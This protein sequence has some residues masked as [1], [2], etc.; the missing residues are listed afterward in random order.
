MEAV[1]ESL[2]EQLG[3]EPTIS[4][5]AKALDMDVKTFSTRLSEGRE[6]KDRMI[7]CNLRLVIA[8][9]RK[10]K[11]KGMNMEDLIQVSEAFNFLFTTV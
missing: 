10:Y 6:G 2:Q 9:A 8:V 11:G 3:R 5:W 1:K 7:R 4:E